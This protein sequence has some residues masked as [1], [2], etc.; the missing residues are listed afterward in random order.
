MIYLSDEVEDVSCKSDSLAALSIMIF[1]GRAQ[2]EYLWH[3]DTWTVLFMEI[4][5]RENMEVRVCII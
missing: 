2:E 5:V 4:C 1:I 3:P